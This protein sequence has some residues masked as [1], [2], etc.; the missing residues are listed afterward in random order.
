MELQQLR[1]FVAVAEA[2][3]F[4]RAAERCHVS[5]PSLSQQI[6]KLEEQTG[7]KLFQRLGRRT[8]LTDAGRLLFDRA[9][10]ILFELDDVDRILREGGNLEGGRLV[11]GAIPTIAPYL[12]PAVLRELRQARVD[13]ELRIH[14]DVTENLLALTASGDLDLSLAALPIQ[15]EQLHVEPILTEKLLLATSRDHPLVRRPHLCLD[16]IRDERFILL[17]EVHCLA[18]QIESFCNEHKFK[19]KIVCRSA[20]LA[21]VQAMIAL[22]QGVSLLPAM[23]EPADRTDNGYR[24]L[25]EEAP[26]RTLVVLWHQKRHQTP[27]GARFVATLRSLAPRFG[28]PEPERQSPP[29]PSAVK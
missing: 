29:G 3:N 6:K 7:Q 21:T 20:Q 27:A 22:D 5:Q 17:H 25:E 24:E 18:E 2:G 4:T 9:K 12:L 10:T 15:H 23:A 8:V 13:L 14:E 1:Y 11:V 28:V 26:T 19:P 16:D